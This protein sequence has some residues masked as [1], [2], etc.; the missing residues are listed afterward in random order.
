MI[1]KTKHPRAFTE[2]QLAQIAYLES[3]LDVCI[4]IEEREAQ[5]EAEKTST[6][7]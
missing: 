5:D 4:T 1:D 6:A 2:Y 7:E 3:V